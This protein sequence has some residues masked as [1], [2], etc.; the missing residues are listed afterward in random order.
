MDKADSEIP[1]PIGDS[2]WQWHI[3]G[4]Q[5]SRGDTQQHGFDKI[6]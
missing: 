5:R 6:E 3:R 2:D 4:G 1:D